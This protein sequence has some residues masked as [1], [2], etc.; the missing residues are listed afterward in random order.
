[1][2]IHLYKPL[3][4]LCLL[5]LISSL[6]FTNCSEN[7]NSSNVRNLEV[8][9]LT[10]PIGLDRE[11]PRFS[12]IYD[13]D[14]RGAGQTAYR[15]IVS[16]N[17]ENLENEE[18]N[19]W[20]SG[21]V[22]N[23]DILNIPYEGERL[24]SG[25]K[26]Y[27]KLQVWDQDGNPAS[28]SDTQHFQMGLL[29]R[30]DWQADWITTPDSTV[31]SPLLRSEF[32]IDMEIEW[33]T[34]FVTGVG[35]YEFYLNGEKVGDHVLDPGMTDFRKRILYETY[36]VTDQLQEGE[37]TWGFWLGNG[38][39]RLKREEDRWT[40]YGMNNQFGT[41]MGIVQLHIQ[42]EDGSEEIIGSD[43]GW[44]TD[45][46]PITY[47]NVYGGEDYDARLEQEDW[48]QT[49]FDDSAWEPV[50]VVDRPD[51]I[52]DSQVMPPIRVV[53][54]IEPA[55]QTNPE[56]G[57]FLY[58]L[59][60]NIPGW[61]RL[62]VEGESGTEIK[63]R[64]AETLNDELFPNPLETGD[65]LSTKHQYHGNVWTTYILNGD[66]T[67]TYEPRFF[68]SGFRYIEVQV[69]NPDAIES[70]EIEGRVVHTDLKR[71]GSFASSDT[72]LNK[73]YKASIW[74]QRGNWHGYPEDCPHR[75]KGGYN[76]DGQ[77]IAETSLH[78]FHMHSLYEKWLND[79][80]DAQYENG[81][82]PNT[83]P[84]ILGG[85]G[86][87]IAWGSAYI[88]LPWWMYQYYEDTRLL[89]EHYDSMKDYMNYLRELA[90][91]N[92]ENP[93]EE[94]IINEFGGY[95]DSLGEWE[96]PVHERTGPINPLTNTYYWYLNSL[97]F[98][99]IAGVLGEDDDR[100]EYLAL[101]DT[102]KNA[103]NEK[104]FLADENLYGTEK[105]DQGYLL[106]ALS[107]DMVPSANRQAV[108]NNLIYDIEETSNGHLGTGILG[109]KHLINFLA[110]EGRED[111]IHQVVTKAT[112]PSWGYWIENGATTLWESWNAESSHNHQMFG[113]V[114]EYF[115]KYLAG[116]RAPTNEG[117]STGYKEILIKPYIPD[118]M[119]WVEAS[120]ET[121]RGTVSSRWE[122]TDVGLTLN[123][124]IPANTT[125]RVS[126]PMLEWDYV[127]ISESGELI[128]E[129]GQITDNNKGIS[130]GSE[131][132]GFVLLDLNSGSYEFEMTGE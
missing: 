42:Y 76:G 34:A 23:T 106:F 1:M 96:A 16:D 63:I 37:N 114:N 91:E 21:K 128:W 118:E 8:E 26:Y 127:Q 9:H 121:V 131:A 47:N 20:D 3:Q 64:G 78:D 97:T 41:P 31:S 100:E 119:D 66:G 130:S 103:F 49:G 59:E 61:W 71:N 11:N 27:W 88:L 120:V 4:T 14:T 86:G 48:D 54:T 53:E 36:D 74:S 57:V 60:Q 28:W 81:R 69:D 77:V 72:L 38:A 45:A 29:N 2:T 39:F 79:M 124:T 17:R 44:K 73:I 107:G 24:Q 5:L 126:I 40:W 58:D 94:Y 109:T 102:I 82:I 112:F 30:G 115:Y 6:L 56:P 125:G 67:E 110:E 18:S 113:T 98:A 116:I 90:S 75:E 108:L 84:L 43:G 105:P 7:G 93:D 70:L 68:Y 132:D 46:S 80:K 99:D 12:W 85:T 33:A 123:V 51:V 32:G 101:A 22:N 111:V 122:K 87:G 15:I 52:M 117:T 104:F 65:S 35:Y 10:N 19:L 83:S 25:R 62:T 13:D 55:V 50:K 129:D 95:W 92:D 89:E